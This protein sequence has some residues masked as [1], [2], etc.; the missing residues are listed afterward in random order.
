MSVPLDRVVQFVTGAQ[1]LVETHRPQGR[2]YAFGHVGDGNI[3][4]AVFLGPD[5]GEDLQAVCADLYAKMDELV[6]S[7]GG[8]ICAEHGV[9]VENVDRLSGQKSS[10]ELEMMRRIKSLFDPEGRMNPGKLIS[11]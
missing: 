3:H 5:E 11:G 7:F 4:T 2:L 1:H 9:G 6:W 10:L 8:S